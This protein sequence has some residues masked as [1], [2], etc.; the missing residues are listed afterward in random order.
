VQSEEGYA[1]VFFTPRPP[2][3]LVLVDEMPSLMPLTGAGGG[4]GGSAAQGRAVGSFAAEQ[5]GEQ[6]QE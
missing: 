2:K 3:N 1:P 6:Q 4:G 5:S